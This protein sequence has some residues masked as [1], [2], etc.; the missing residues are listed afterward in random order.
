[1]WRHRS[2]FTPPA[3]PLFHSARVRSDAAIIAD[4]IAEREQRLAELGV[5]A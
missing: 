2:E 4:Q 5:S 1:L 3:S